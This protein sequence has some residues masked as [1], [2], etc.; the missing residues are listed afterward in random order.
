MYL[1]LGFRRVGL[2]VV[3]RPLVAGDQH[4]RGGHRRTLRAPPRARPRRRSSRTSTSSPRRRDEGLVTG[5]GGFIGS[6]VV[7]A[8]LARGDDVRVLDNFS[9]GSRANLA[10]LENDVELVE[11]DLRSYE[12]VHAAVRGVEVVFHQGAL[13]LGSALGPGSADDDRGQ[14]R[15][16]AERPARR[17]RRGRAPRR[18]RVVL[19]GLRQHRRAAARRD[20]GARPDLAVRRREARGRALLH[21]LQPRVR[22]WRS[23]SLRYFNVFGPRQD[24]TSQ[25]AAV[26]PAL[27]PRDRRRRAG[28]DLRRRRAVARLH[29]RR[30]RRRGE[31]PRRG[32]G[33]S[34]RA[35][36]STSPP[37]GS[38]DRERARRR[39]SAD[40]SGKPVEK[41]L[42]AAR[43][44]PTC[45]H[46]WADVER[47][48]APPR[49]RA[50]GRLRRRAAAH[51]RLPPR[52]RTDDGT[53]IRIARRARRGLRLPQDPQAARRDGV[54]RQRDRLP[55]GLRG[56]PPLPRHAGRALLRPLGRGA[57]RG[58][59][60][61]AHPRAGRAPP[62]RVD[63][64]AQ[65]LERERDGGSRHPRRRRQ[66]RLR[67]AR[68]PHGRRGR[69]RAPRRVR[70]LGGSTA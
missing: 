56:L 60:R 42:R 43:A 53:R 54:R 45:A 19:V 55:A 30:Q 40:C 70:Q 44:R 29:L 5:G 58:R 7:R 34:R 9:T 46:S 26:V 13:P 41:A 25:Y 15:G 50:A 1:D 22:R 14:R 8:L 28:D 33:R 11:G 27:H 21:E 62:R 39:R 20:A 3:A 12:R 10:G 6:N 49:L 64:A 63:D 47:G 51:R 61:G 17:A 31:P 38:V 36:S 59:G 4:R 35:R 66:G 68:R 37:A 18:Q 2:G 52:E 48:A 23:S 65:G 16:H 57:R 67:R 24:P 69:H 32:R